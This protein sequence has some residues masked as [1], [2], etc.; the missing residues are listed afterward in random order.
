MLNLIIAGANV[1]K[2]TK[3]EQISLEGTF[4]SNKINNLRPQI[5]KI[6][7]RVIIF[8]ERM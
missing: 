5:I 6:K 2:K 4:T 1:L 7:W 3:F 8:I